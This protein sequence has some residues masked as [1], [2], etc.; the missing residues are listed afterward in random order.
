MARARGLYG[1]ASDNGD[2]R[3]QRPTGRHTADN[4]RASNGWRG[5][6]RG[7]SSHTGGGGSEGARPLDWERRTVAVGELMVWEE[8]FSPRFTF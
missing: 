6:E 8:E 7:Q 2:G 4:G 5:R 1:L 3:G